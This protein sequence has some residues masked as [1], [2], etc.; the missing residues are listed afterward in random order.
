MGRAG[1]L[2]LL[3]QGIALGGPFA[4]L[5]FDLEELVEL[6][7]DGVEALILLFNF[8]S[9]VENFLEGVLFLFELGDALGE[10]EITFFGFFEC[11]V[12]VFDAVFDEAELVDFIKEIFFE[13]LGMFDGGL[14]G[15]EFF[16]AGFF[17]GLNVLLGG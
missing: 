3:V 4:V 5:L 9:P 6:L 7:I 13:L 1:F 12:L 17:L 10:F 16:L 11:A 14:E 8:I 2:N 15:S